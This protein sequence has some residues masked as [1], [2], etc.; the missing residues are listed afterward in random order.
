MPAITPEEIIRLTRHAPDRDGKA[1][2]TCLREMKLGFVGG[3]MVRQGRPPNKGTPDPN[4]D[5]WRVAAGAV[6][7]G[8]GGIMLEY[9]AG[10]GPS[11][12][13]PGGTSSAPE[14]ASNVDPYPGAWSVQNCVDW[15]DYLA[16]VHGADKLRL[17]EFYNEPATM[18]D[19]QLGSYSHTFWYSSELFNN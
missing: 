3:S 15:A 12:G 14:L 2:L 9:M 4:Y 7:A 17:A 11:P 5:D 16:S 18:N 13:M 8:D 10:V 1:W 19:L 6:V